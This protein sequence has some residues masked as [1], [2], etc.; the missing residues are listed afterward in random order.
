MARLRAID[1]IDR[2]VK[3]TAP[4]MALDRDTR[5]AFANRAYLKGTDGAGEQVINRYVFDVSA[6]VP[7]RAKFL[8]RKFRRAQNGQP[9]LLEA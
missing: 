4:V 8:K 3:K 5:F 2:L 7:E 1:F 9:I 6:E